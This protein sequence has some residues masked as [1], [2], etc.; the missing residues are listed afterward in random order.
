[1]KR[2]QPEWMRSLRIGDVLEDANG[3]Q[4][5]VRY[6]KFYKDGD[7]RSVAFAIKRCSWTGRPYT[8]L[9]YSDLKTR[10]FRPTNVR[11][12][13]GSSLDWKIYAEIGN[14]RI[15]ALLSCCAVK[16]VA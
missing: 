13:M 4:R 14:T 7:L 2:C 15:R 11:V 9:G 3:S 8:M 6:V 16:G 12:R 1:M 5:V 10:G